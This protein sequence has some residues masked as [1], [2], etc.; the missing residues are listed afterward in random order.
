MVD[1]YEKSKADNEIEVGDVVVDAEENGVVLRIDNDHAE[2]LWAC[3]ITTTMIKDSLRKTGKRNENIIKAMK[4][5]G[6]I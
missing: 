5:L 4:E 6:E 2:V 3:G 1:A